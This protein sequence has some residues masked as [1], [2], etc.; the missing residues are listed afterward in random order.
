M[1]LE[2]VTILVSPCFT[3]D[4]AGVEAIDISKHSD[5]MRWILQRYIG[6]DD[7]CAVDEPHQN[8]ADKTLWAGRKRIVVLYVDAFC[9]VREGCSL[10][11]N[12]S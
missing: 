2:T 5:K 3:F 8:G 7:I 1:H 11:I 6:E 10:T 12:G 9:T 4:A